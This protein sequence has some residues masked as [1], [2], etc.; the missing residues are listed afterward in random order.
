MKALA[1]RLAEPRR[2]RRAGRAVGGGRGAETRAAAVPALAGGRDKRS[3]PASRAA[4]SHRNSKARSRIWRRLAGGLARRR[5]ARR[6]HRLVG[7]DARLRRPDARIPAPAAG[8][9]GDSRGHRD[10]RADA[11]DGGRRHRLRLDLADAALDRARLRQRRA[12]ADRGFARARHVAAGG[13]GKIALPSAL[14]DILAGARL[15][16]TVA[17]ILSVVCEMIAGLDGLAPGSCSPPAPIAA[18]T[19][20][21]AS[22]CS[23][24]SGTTRSTS[25]AR[26]LPLSLI[27][28]AVTPLQGIQSSSVSGSPSPMGL[29]ISRFVRGSEA[30]KPSGTCGFFSRARVRCIDRGTRRGI[31]RLSNAQDRIAG[32]LFQRR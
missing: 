31:R 16:L 24:P 17:L 26:S 22:C 11:A 30:A 3:S 7:A 10:L 14:P 9:G 4:I 19:F 29:A 21:L 18:P 13:A 20:S 28:M 23:A 2:T 5:R 27:L 15:G 25:H 32:T 8:L 6:A 12:A 1:W